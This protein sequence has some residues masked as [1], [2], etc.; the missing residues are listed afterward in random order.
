MIPNNNLSVLPWYDS[1]ERQNARKWWV[2]D[3]VYPLYV[4]SGYIL[5]FQ[6]MRPTRTELAQGD[7]LEAQDGDKGYL[8]SDGSWYQDNTSGYVEEY[9]VVGIDAVYLSDIPYPVLG[10]EYGADSVSYVAY[11]SNGKVLLAVS[12]GAHPYSGFWTLPEGTTKIRVL[13]S[14]KE[15]EEYN[16]KVYKTDRVPKAIESFE[17]YNRCDER[18]GDFIPFMKATGLSVKHLQSQDI[19]VVVYQGFISISDTFAEGQYYAVMSDGTD[20]WYSEMFT[21]SKAASSYLKIEWWDVEDFVMDAGTIVYTQPTFRN[22]LYIPT[23][24]AKPEYEFEEESE[25]RDGYI[26][27]IKQISKKTFHFAF[28]AS[29]YMLDVMRFIRMSDYVEITYKG[30][31]Y[32]VDSFLLSPE[33]TDYGDVAL[34][35]VAFTTATVAKK[36]GLAYVKSKRLDFSD[37]FNNDYN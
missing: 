13:T 10:G 28:T 17:I 2:Y 23:D 21:V 3:K 14:N 9:D 8:T 4:P 32:S 29:E 34:V 25:E 26:F 24:I 33:W 18:L 36:V 22:R 5:P 20:T 19:D 11:D 35:D 30:Q 6:V 15:V 37:D 27:P 31:R 16:G 12:A 1:I 7:I